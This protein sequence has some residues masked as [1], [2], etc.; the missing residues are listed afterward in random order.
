MVPC[1]EPEGE[2]GKR[3]RI[4][5]RGCNDVSDSAEQTAGHFKS[6]IFGQPTSRPIEK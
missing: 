3:R 5:E 4:E 6:G 1:D 2:E